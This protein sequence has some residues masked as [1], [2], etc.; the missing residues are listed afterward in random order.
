V[1][2][3]LGSEAVSPRIPITRGV[4]RSQFHGTRQDTEDSLHSIRNPQSSARPSD[5]SI[6]KVQHAKLT[7]QD[8]LRLDVPVHNMLLVQV[9]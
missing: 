5:L 6:R 8:I 3:Y 4:L 2:Q 9:R 7:N 1:S